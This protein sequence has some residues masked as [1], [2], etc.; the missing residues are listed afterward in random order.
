MA[1]VYRVAYLT[2]VHA[3]VWALE[4]VLADLRQQAPDLVVVG[5][6]LTFKFSRPR[7]TLEL[8]GGIEHLAIA[9]NS[10]L[11]VTGWAEPGNW[12]SFLP[13]HGLAHARWTRAAIGEEWARYLARLPDRLTLSVAGVDDVLV[14]HGAPGDPFFGIHAA[15][16]PQQPAPR[17]STS[18]TVLDKR[19]AGVR[20]KLILCG[21][22]HVP[23][24]RPWRDVLLVNPGAVAH[25]WRDSPGPQL[26][27]YASLT[28]RASHGWAVELRA[29]PYDHLGAAADLLA[30]ETGFAQA[31]HLADL[32][33]GRAV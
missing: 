1:S 32:L 25:G 8:L 24:V 31:R 5:G 26:A 29:I 2:D 11:Y 3:N 21:H 9:G 4:A 28:Y 7:E 27:R 19:F 10:E 16:D 23:L 33:R 30:M 22:T 12:P 6:D 20:A 17:W 18:D 13:A 14:V 15:P